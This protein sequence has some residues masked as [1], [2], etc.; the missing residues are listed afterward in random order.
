MRL[1]HSDWDDLCWLALIFSFRRLFKNNF[2][3]E[4]TK[5][6]QH[7]IRRSDIEWGLQFLV[8]NVRSTKTLLKGE[9]VLR[10]PLAMS[11]NL[12]FDVWSRLKRHFIS[13]PTD[14]DAVL[15]QKLDRIGCPMPLLYKDVLCFI[16]KSVGSRLRPPKH[17][18]AFLTQEWAILPPLNW[19]SLGGY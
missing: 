18:I 8:V 5:M 14:R 9:R 15:F 16:K 17:W 11:Q 1:T 10:I 2:L 6:D 12:V 4:G 7:S 19:D 13:V 3:P